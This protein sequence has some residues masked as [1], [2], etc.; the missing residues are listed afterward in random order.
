MAKNTGRSRSS[1][2]PSSPPP[3]KPL[4]RRTIGRL[5]VWGAAVALLGVIF[6]VTAV[7]FTAR[8]LPDYNALKSSQNG[9][10]IVVRARDG[11]ELVSLGPSYGRWLPYCQIPPIMKDAMISIEARRL[12]DPYGAERSGNT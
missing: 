12:R 11:S 8:E 9:Q 1:G 6:L 10:M 2:G 5:F 7:A 3:R 4:W